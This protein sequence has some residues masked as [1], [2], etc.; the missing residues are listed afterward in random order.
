MKNLVDGVKQYINNNFEEYKE[1]IVQLTKIPAPSH[2]EAKRVEFLLAYLKAMGLECHSDSAQNVIIDSFYMPAKPTFLFM[3]H[4]DT[5]F[6]DE[7]EIPVVVEDG[8]IKGPG[9]GDDTTNVAAIIMTLKYI[10]K[11]NIKSEHSVLFVLNSCE[12]G[13]GNLKGSRKIMKDYVNDINAMISFDGNYKYVCNE[14]VGSKRYE[15]SINTVGGHS[16]GDFGNANAIFYM[17]KLISKL[18]E[19]DTLKLAGKNTFNVGTITGGT[20]VNTIAQNASMLFEFRSNND[21]SREELEKQFE[22]IIRDFQNENKGEMDLLVKLVGNRPTAKGVDE[23]KLQEMT[24]KA[25]KI[26]EI[27]ANFTAKTTSASTDCNI[28]LSMGIPAICYGTYMGGGQHT[29]EE[30]VNID[31]LAGGLAIAMLSVLVEICGKSIDNLL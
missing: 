12:E 27:G 5:V 16:Y 14:A 25:Q 28:P 19:I 24:K 21:A 6:P 23:N 2:K 3:A 18:Y 9:V 4:I 26:I 30:Y 13:L 11:N 31:S 1:L 29:R 7:T 17:S 8:K 20:S 10:L 22:T 15:I